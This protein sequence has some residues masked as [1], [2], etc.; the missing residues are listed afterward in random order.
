M[1]K[2][3]KQ[4]PAGS[5]FYIEIYLAK[6]MMK[7]YMRIG[8]VRKQNNNTQ[9]MNNHDMSTQKIPNLHVYYLDKSE[10]KISILMIPYCMSVLRTRS[11]LKK[12]FSIHVTRTR[13]NQKSLI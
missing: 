10:S 2:R 9:K 7:L 5:Y 4:V 1:Q 12:V 6:F 3:H 8:P 13:A 11:Y